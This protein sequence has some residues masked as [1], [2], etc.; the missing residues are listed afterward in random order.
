MSRMSEPRRVTR[1]KVLATGLATLGGLLA[2]RARALAGPEDCTTPTPHQTEGPFFPEN[3]RGEQ[4][5]DLTRLKGRGGP[6][7]GDVVVVSGRILDA[8]CRPIK[9]AVIEIWQAN[10]WGRYD[11]ERDADNPRRLDP[12]FQGRARLVTGADG[13]YQFKTIKP[14]A[15]PGDDRGWMRPPHIHFKISRRGFRELTTQMYF[16]GEELNEPDYVRGELTPEEQ[17]AVTVA[18]EPAPALGK[19]ART[20]TFDITLERVG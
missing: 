6:A 12:N 19:G 1:R 2:G 4:D 10:H 3:G 11:H 15:Y 17:A 20:G 16:A 7:Q 18:F 9:D 13:G 5:A 14:G 8:E